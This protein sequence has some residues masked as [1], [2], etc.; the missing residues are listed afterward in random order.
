MHERKQKEEQL[1]EAAMKKSLT[2]MKSKKGFMIVDNYTQRI[3]AG[4]EYGFSLEDVE[5]FLK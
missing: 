4:H 5:R 1:K 2:V 3:I